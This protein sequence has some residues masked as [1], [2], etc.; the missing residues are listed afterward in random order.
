[1]E[2]LIAQQAEQMA[3]QAAEISRLRSALEEKTRHLAASHLSYAN[4]LARCGDL[5]LKLAGRV[6]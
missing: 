5:E 2:E 1:M 4:A 3:Q 6:V